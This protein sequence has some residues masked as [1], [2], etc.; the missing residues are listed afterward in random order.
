MSTSTMIFIFQILSGI[1]WTLVYIL[2]IKRGFQDK[3]YGMPL[4]ALAANVSWEFIYSFILPHTPPQLYVDY[5]WLTFDIVIVIQTLI[6]GKKALKDILPGNWF[7]MVFIL[8]LITAFGTVL[9]MSYEFQNPDGRYA[10]FGQNLMMSILFVTMLLQRKNVDGQSLYIAIFKMVGTLLPAILTFLLCPQSKLLHFLSIMIFIFD[11]IY[12]V[13]VYKK[14]RK[15]K[16][17]PWLRL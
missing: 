16:I 2:I 7:Y 9:L 10:A 5:V 1:F 8:S 13:M 14:C 17:N 15:L 6:F 12:I 11:C 4:A 3:T